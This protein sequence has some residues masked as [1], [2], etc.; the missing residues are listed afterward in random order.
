MFIGFADCLQLGSRRFDEEHY[1]D[2]VLPERHGLSYK[3]I[4][5]HPS[6]L[7]T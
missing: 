4:Q 2:V 3:R 6:E 5:E 1:F 7:D